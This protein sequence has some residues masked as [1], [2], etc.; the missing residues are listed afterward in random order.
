MSSSPLKLLPVSREPTQ[1]IQPDD[2]MVDA[3]ANASVLEVPND[4]KRP[5]EVRI[6]TH[7]P[8][9]TLRHLTGSYHGRRDDACSEACGRFFFTE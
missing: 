8:A 7:N 4:N 6:G 5:L 3:G 1:T 9:H 2:P